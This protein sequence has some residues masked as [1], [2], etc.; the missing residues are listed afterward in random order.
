MTTPVTLYGTQSNGETLPVQVDDTGRLVAE[1]LQGPKGDPGEQGP[2]GANGGSFPLPADPY[3][4]ALLGWLNNE[5][6]WVGT[7][8]VPI[9]EGVFG[10]MTSV[11]PSGVITVEETIPSE[12]GTGVYLIQCDREGKY[13]N[14]VSGFDMRKDWTTTAVDFLAHQSFVLSKGFDGNLDTSTLSE[15]DFSLE[16]LIDEEVS[17]ME[18]MITSGINSA[19]TFTVTVNDSDT[20]VITGT[21]SEM[22]AN[23]LSFSINA[24]LSKV[25]V[26]R[27]GAVTGG[28]VY[29]KVDGKTL[30]LP[31]LGKVE[32]RVDQKID[33]SSLQIVNTNAY[34]FVA[35][36]YLKI[37]PQRVAPWVLYG[38]D[39]TSL[40]DHLRN[41]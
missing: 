36:E 14:P 23:P 15:T 37:T 38:N 13:T 34:A 40:I 24:P 16:G 32:G 20:K 28:F 25:S 26:N 17:E 7:P 11:D 2:P 6:A 18:I 3:E 19:K 27:G 12:V 35:G 8:P 4:G 31:E 10:P 21:D 41:T 5:L 1:G 39:P 22:R 29:I 30:V 33:D 9:P